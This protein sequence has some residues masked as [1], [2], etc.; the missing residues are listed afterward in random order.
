MYKLCA[1]D[2]DGTLADTLADIAYAANHALELQGFPTWSVDEYRQKV[3]YGMRELCRRALPE[4]LRRDE[5]AV[6]KMMSMFDSYYREHCCVRTELFPGIRELLDKLHDA[7]IMCAIITN[8][9]EVQTGIVLDELFKPDDFIY[10]KG[11]TDQNY[12]KPDPRLFYDC[13]KALSVEPKETV[14]VGDSDVDVIFACNA[15]VDSVG[16]AW[17]IRGRAELEA[18]GAT[19]TADTADEVYRF[20]TGK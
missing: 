12:K 14:Y 19:F 9:S 1:F 20:I 6:D 5:A 7:G 3:G 2:M 15:G 13:M 10:V 4:E 8:K 18:A 17:G 11:L 16:A